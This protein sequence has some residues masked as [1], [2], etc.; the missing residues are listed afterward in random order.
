MKTE[1]IDN[2]AQSRFEFPLGDSLAAAYYRIEDRRIVLVHTEAPQEFSGRG[3]GSKLARSVFEIIR[4]SRRRV[5]AK[6]PFMAAYA[7]R[8]PELPSCWTAELGLG[9]ARKRYFT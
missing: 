1:V 6:C 9:S 5:I 2:P 4:K 3:I 7:A 8:H